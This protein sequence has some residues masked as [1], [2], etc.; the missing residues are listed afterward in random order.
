[1]DMGWKMHG[2]EFMKRNWI[3]PP[4]A[5]RNWRVVC[6]TVICVL[7]LISY[8]KQGCTGASR[9]SRRPVSKPLQQARWT[10]FMVWLEW[11]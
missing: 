4:S 2:P 1:M 11:G 5:I 7:S 3:F 8:V 9:K 10:T 6:K